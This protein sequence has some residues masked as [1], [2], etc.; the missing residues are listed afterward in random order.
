MSRVAQLRTY[1]IEDGRLDEFVRAWREGV[2]PL[3]RAAGFTVEGAWTT[4]EGSGF[5]WII[6][7]AG[8]PAEFEERDAAYYASPERRDLEPDPARLIAAAEHHLMAPVE[9]PDV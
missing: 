4:A 2:V 6:S 8:G 9:L 5:V 7:C 1:R 3:R